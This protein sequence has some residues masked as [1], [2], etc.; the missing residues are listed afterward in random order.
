[1]PEG[2]MSCDI[3]T[4]SWECTRAKGHEGPC[5]AVPRRTMEE[6]KKFYELTDEE[7]LGIRNVL[8]KRYRDINTD[9]AKVRDLIA[10]IDRQYAARNSPGNPAYMEK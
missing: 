9:A 8:E 1:M 7:Y 4:M 5:A 3:P 10:K 2:I 6:P